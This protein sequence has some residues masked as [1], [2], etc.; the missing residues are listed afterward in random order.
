M[1]DERITYDLVLLLDPAA[2]DGARQAL[3]AST[4]TAIEAAGEIIRHD[5]WG[6]RQLAY[7]IAHKSEAE[8][9]LMQFHVRDV[10]LL[11]GLDRSLQLADSVLRFMI[12]KLDPGTPDPPQLG[13]RAS[14]QGE[15]EPVPAAA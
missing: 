9:H 8:Y 6:R 13:G 7:P 5:E 14:R 2:E 12:T 11:S 1:S 4:R 3:L 10:S 15:A